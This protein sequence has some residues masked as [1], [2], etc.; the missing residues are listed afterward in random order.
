M[1]GCIRIVDLYRENG[2]FVGSYPVSLRGRNYVP[3][4]REYELD[5]IDTAIE[6]ALVRVDERRNLVAR[7]RRR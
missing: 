7:I 4:E 3:S 2:A 6:D 5:A 1:N